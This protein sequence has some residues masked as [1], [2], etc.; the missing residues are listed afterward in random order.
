MK[1]D[2]EVLMIR[3]HSRKQNAMQDNS[4]YDCR[5]K[6]PPKNLQNYKRLRKFNFMT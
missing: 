6:E 1:F 4:I 3:K 2:Y 5:S